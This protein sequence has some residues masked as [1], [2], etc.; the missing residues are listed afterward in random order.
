MYCFQ[1]GEKL[2]KNSKFCSTCG[3]SQSIN[4][5]VDIPKKVKVE[6]GVNL[7]TPKNRLFCGF[8]TI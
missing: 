3:K 7:K 8:F 4:I 2:S 5:N 1:C 6:A